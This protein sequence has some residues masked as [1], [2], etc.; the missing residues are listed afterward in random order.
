MKLPIN[1]QIAEISSVAG[2]KTDVAIM[3]GLTKIRKRKICEYATNALKN[4]R[5]VSKGTVW[6]SV[7]YG[8]TGAG[9][10]GLLVRKRIRKDETRHVETPVNHIAVQIES[11]YFRRPRGV[12]RG[13]GREK[14][15]FGRL[16]PSRGRRDSVRESEMAARVVSGGGGG[17]GGGCCR[18]GCDSERGE[19]AIKRSAGGDESEGDD[20]E[21]DGE[22]E[23]L[24]GDG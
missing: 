1:A 10:G 11:L 24:S 12:W 15:S 3:T 21:G 22:R 14:T 7:V 9:L 20:R 16:C 6:R 4:V 18:G 17:G 19:V 2:M 23:G 5:I 13:S 8:V